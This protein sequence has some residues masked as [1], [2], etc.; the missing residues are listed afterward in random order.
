MGQF[1]PRRI[2]RADL[3]AARHT[4]SVTKALRAAHLCPMPAG[5]KREGW[6]TVGPEN[7][8]VNG[9]IITVRKPEDLS[10]LDQAAYIVADAL[11]RAEFAYWRNEERA[12]TEGI[13]T[14]ERAHKKTKHELAE[15]LARNC[16]AFVRRAHREGATG[17]RVTADTI[18]C[19]AQELHI[20]ADTWLVKRAAR[21]IVDE[22]QI[23]H[24]LHLVD[25]SNDSFTIRPKR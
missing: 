13:V 6:L 11:Y 5:S 12:E 4:A 14:F 3:T 15:D 24:E 22:F 8:L 20:D 1:T 25:F 2:E 21:L 17:T 18:W 19:T 10:S 23:Q 16:Q 9:A 7:G